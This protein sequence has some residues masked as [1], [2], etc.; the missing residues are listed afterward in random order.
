MSNE[1][2]KD[3]ATPLPT[4][5]QLVATVARQQEQ[6]NFLLVQTQNLYQRLQLPPVPMNMQGQQE[7]RTETGMGAIVSPDKSSYL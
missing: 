1:T 7:L 4:I 6:I 3:S 5:T 2:S